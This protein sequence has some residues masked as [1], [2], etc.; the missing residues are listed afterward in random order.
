[1]YIVIGLLSLALRLLLVKY[2]CPV[3]LL[4]SAGL[5]RSRQE[6][7]SINLSFPR[8]HPSIDHKQTDIYRT[9]ITYIIQLISHNTS[10]QT[11]NIKY[12]SRGIKYK[13][14]GNKY[15]LAPK[16]GAPNCPL[17]EWWFKTFINWTTPF[18]CC[19]W[20][21]NLGWYKMMILIS[22]A[23]MEKKPSKE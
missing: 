15:S 10:Q 7:D 13:C 5:R 22:Y 12:I 17:L 6:I 21:R 18:N 14:L 4:L 20:N 9:P 16:N 11:Y 23:D 8:E 2:P 3:P 19:I 1:M